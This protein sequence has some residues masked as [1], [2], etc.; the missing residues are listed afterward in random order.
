[1]DSVIKG[2]SDEVEKVCTNPIPTSGTLTEASAL[3]SWNEER[4]EI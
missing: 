4:L 2:L 3:A 1:M